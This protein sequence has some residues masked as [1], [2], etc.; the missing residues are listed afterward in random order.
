M[1]PLD[2]DMDQAISRAKQ[3]GDR[4][5]DAFSSGMSSKIKAGAGG[6][7][8]ALGT[9]QA[10]KG[11]IQGVLQSAG[12]ISGVSS[13][14]IY[15]QQNVAFSTLLRDGPKA[16]SLINE[17][18]DL[19]SKTPFS[20]VDLVGYA[21]QLLATGFAADGLRQ[22]IGTIADT[23]AA[24]GL[25]S[26]GV[27]R[28]ALVLGQVRSGGIQGDDLRQFKNAGVNLAEV[29][30][31]GMGRKFNSANEAMS[32]LRSLSPDQQAEAIIKGMDKRFGGMAEKLGT[33]T[34][35]GITQNLS[36]KVDLMM[37]PTGTL[38]LN[39]NLK[40]GVGILSYLLGGLQKLNEGTNGAAGALGLV[41]LGIPIVKGFIAELGLARVALRNLAGVGS[42]SLSGGPISITGGPIYLNGSAIGGGVPVGG[43]GTTAAASMAAEAASRDAKMKMFPGMPGAGTVVMTQPGLLPQAG[44]L[45]KQIGGGVLAMLKNPFT[46]TGAAALVGGAMA[47]SDNK[48]VSA[49]GGVLNSAAGGALIGGVIGSFIPVVGNIVGAAAGGIIGAVGDI[50]QRVYEAVK[51]KEGGKGGSHAAET[52]KN[53]AEAT[54]V[55]K[56]LHGRLVGGG[57]R[58][59]NSMSRIELD[60]AM[61]SYQ[62]AAFGAGLG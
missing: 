13:A 27:G 48:G 25:Q 9:Y 8:A 32:G 44:N 18:Y 23:A 31:L 35:A 1:R 30:G 22:K 29:A 47:S 21:R 43:A 11:Q 56:Q 53:T 51:E 2:R 50:G 33:Q 60:Y 7:L 5:G 58:A 54:R 14:G 10:I 39:S 16:K 15:E 24:L 26:E 55:L 34:F 62:R 57:A 59:E 4:A 38:L 3:G 41:A 6:I 42:R 28:L 45:V 49:V 52:A 37:R 61:F 20:S 36:E 17:L 12:E 46:V 19:G 40:Q